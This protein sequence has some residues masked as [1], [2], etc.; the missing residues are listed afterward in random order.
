MV[1][2]PWLKG[3]ADYGTLAAGYGDAGTMAEE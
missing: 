3:N 1:L 2:A